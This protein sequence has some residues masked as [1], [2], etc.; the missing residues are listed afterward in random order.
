MTKSHWRIFCYLPGVKNILCTCIQPYVYHGV[1]HIYAALSRMFAINGNCSPL[2]AQVPMSSLS[3]NLQGSTEMKLLLTP[4][5]SLSTFFF[6]SWFSTKQ[7]LP[8]ISPTVQTK[9]QQFAN[10]ETNRFSLLHLY[11]SLY[12]HGKRRAGSLQNLMEKQIKFL[13]LRPVK[14]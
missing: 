4:L 14:S 3:G 8:R 1:W 7:T 12:A 13:A 2:K 11:W 10:T 6:F 5:Y 9:L